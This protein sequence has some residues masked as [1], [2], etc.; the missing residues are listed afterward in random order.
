[1]NSPTQT[2]PTAGAMRAP[3]Y[4]ASKTIRRN[5]GMDK[6]FEAV[7][8]NR[9]E[10]KIAAYICADSYAECD[11]QAA[12]VT[13]ALNHYETGVADLVASLEEVLT[14]TEDQ[15]WGLCEHVRTLIERNVRAVLA[16]HASA[17]KG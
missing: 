15:H 3:H 16:R 11:A 13:K 2:Q 9:E 5:P 8:Y 6:P 10:T 4:R 7:I 17:G 12:H 14:H 1:M